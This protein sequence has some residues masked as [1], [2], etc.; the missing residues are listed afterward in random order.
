MK[1]FKGKANFRQD[2]SDHRCDNSTCYHKEL[3]REVGGHGPKLNIDKFFSS[4]DLFDNLTKHKISC[5]R[6]VWPKRKGIPLDLLVQNER[7][8]CGNIRSRTRHDGSG[9][10]R[11]MLCV[12][13]TNMHSP[14]QQK[15][16]FMTKMEML[17]CHK[18]YRVITILCGTLTKVTEWPTVTQSN[19]GHGNGK[20]AFFPPVN[21]DYCEHIPSPDIMWCQKDT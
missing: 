17:W 21:H 11:W 15:A 6:T 2:T 20:K 4:P 12:C 16:T 8:K 10:D 7:P 13:V 3:D 14:L 18:F 9:L 1:F 19:G 5:C